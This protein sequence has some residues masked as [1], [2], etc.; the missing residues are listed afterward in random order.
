[1]PHNIYHQPTGQ[2]SELE[3]QRMRENSLTGGG[4]TAP[5]PYLTDA[6]R[7]QTGAGISGMDALNQMRDTSPTGGALGEIT[8]AEMGALNALNQM[9][10]QSQTGGALGQISDAEMGAMSAL[11]DGIPREFSGDLKGQMSDNKLRRKNSLT[12][13]YKT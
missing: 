13:N 4:R 9:S 12:E 11:G 8:E 10:E 2:I 5:N 6:L 1:M 3:L 7:N